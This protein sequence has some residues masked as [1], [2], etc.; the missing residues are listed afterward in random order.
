MIVAFLAIGAGVVDVAITLILGLSFWQAFFLFLLLLASF[1]AVWY[2]LEY[3]A[4]RH[5]E[6]KLDLSCWLTISGLLCL[7][8]LLL[9]VGSHRNGH[10]LKVLIIILGLLLMATGIFIILQECRQDPIR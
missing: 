10:L 5:E 7:A 1:V 3:F 2:G 8:V 6:W 9:M 4:E